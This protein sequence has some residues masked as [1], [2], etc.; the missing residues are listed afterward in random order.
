MKLITVTTNG[1]VKQA[2]VHINTHNLAEY[3][4]VMQFSGF[5][6]VTTVLKVPDEKVPA[7]W[8]KLGL[9]PL[10]CPVQIKDGVVV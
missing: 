9:D 10:T 1:T 2:C 4:F 3:V 7:V 6:Q 5:G 8:R